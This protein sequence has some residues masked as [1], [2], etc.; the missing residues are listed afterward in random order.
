MPRIVNGTVAWITFRATMGRKRAFLFAIPGV[1]LLLVTVALKAGGAQPSTWVA[2]ILGVF[3]FSVVIPL[4]ALVIGTSVVGS[5]IDDG[6]I[7]HLLSTP[8][9]RSSV[10]LTKF[11]VAAGLTMAFAALPELLAGLVAS[12]GVSR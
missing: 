3:G 6:S 2:P 4:T 11:A 7:V 5:E 10:V 9:P 8:V 1:I 12:G